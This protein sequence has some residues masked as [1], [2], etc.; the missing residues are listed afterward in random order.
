[1]ATCL[2]RHKDKPVQNHH[3]A[4]L[5]CIL[6]MSKSPRPPSCQ[7]SPLLIYQTRIRS[8]QL[9]SVDEPWRTHRPAGLYVSL[10]GLQEAVMRRLGDYPPSILYGTY[11][12]LTRPRPAGLVTSPRNE[13]LLQHGK[14]TRM[15]NGCLLWHPD[16]T[17]PCSD[18]LQ[19]E[20]VNLEMSAPTERMSQQAGW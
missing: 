2:P 17:G 6:S 9:F 13:R 19:R 5:A 1:L 18:R 20:A 8:R 11:Q 14:S 15:Q 7:V 12:P 3:L 16:S 10:A 4:I